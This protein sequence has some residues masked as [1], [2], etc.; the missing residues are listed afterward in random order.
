MHT[1]A[2][3][4]GMSE[5]RDKGGAK[6]MISSGH[7]DHLH[8]PAWPHEVKLRCIIPCKRLN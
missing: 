4:A 5:G 2:R 7:M 3:T 8:F 6:D 1:L